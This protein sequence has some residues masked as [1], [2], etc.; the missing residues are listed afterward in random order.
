MLIGGVFVAAY[1]YSEDRVVADGH[2]I[3]S[4]GPGTT[5]EFALAIVKALCGEETVAK[6]SPPMMLK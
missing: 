6:I 1:V 2:L 5:F 3:T 4:R